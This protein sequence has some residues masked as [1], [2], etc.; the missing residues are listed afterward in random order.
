ME[1]SIG[2]YKVRVIILIA[3]VVVFWVMFGHILCGCCRVSLFEGLSSAVNV[4]SNIN[5]NIN[6]DIL[7]NRAKQMGLDELKT[8]TI[9]AKMD[10]ETAE[11]RLQGTSGTIRNSLKRN[12]DNIK[13]IYDIY[14]N[15][16]D[17]R[18]S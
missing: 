15:E 13:E 5:S 17:K 9:K 7:K 11:K 10:F 6:S 12:R 1:I 3:I 18:E 16:L 4:S 2:S 8:K 14:K